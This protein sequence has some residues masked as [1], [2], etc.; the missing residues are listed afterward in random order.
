[1]EDNP[2]LAYDIFYAERCLFCE[3]VMY[4]TFYLVYFN[5]NYIADIAMNDD[6]EWMLE[7][8]AVLPQATIDEIGRNIE[9]RYK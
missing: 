6:M 2:I 3:T 5:G 9:S 4:D 1:M 7:S 8:G